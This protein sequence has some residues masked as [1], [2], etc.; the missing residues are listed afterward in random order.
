[1]KLFIQLHS[2]A[3]SELE[4]RKIREI[5]LLAL[6]RYSSVV[7]KVNVHIFKSESIQFESQFHTLLIVTTRTSN[8][9]K[10]ECDS[11][12]FIEG[13]RMILL[14]AKRYL[15]RPNIDYS[16]LSSKHQYPNSDKDVSPAA[17]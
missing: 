15:S 8:N 6:S 10:I 4:Q 9:F 7:T 17:E 11:G 3:V 14:R 2:F 1:M 16:Y 5:I 12:D 13:V